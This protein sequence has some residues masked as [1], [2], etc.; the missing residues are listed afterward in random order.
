MVWLIDLA[1]SYDHDFETCINNT[2]LPTLS[3]SQDF[4]PNLKISLQ[5]IKISFLLLLFSSATVQ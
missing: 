5:Y 3:E 1:T 2:G 4:G